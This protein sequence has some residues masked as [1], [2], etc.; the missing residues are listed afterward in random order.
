V[1]HNYAMRNAIK[2]LAVLTV[3]LWVTAVT[4]P[5]NGYLFG[6]GGCVAASSALMCA[7]VVSYREEEVVSTRG[8]LVYK[9]DSKIRFFISYLIIGIVVFAFLIACT[10]NFFIQLAAI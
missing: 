8:G 10:F 3:V 1:L 9:K 5:L 4:F 6:Y 2:I 7:L